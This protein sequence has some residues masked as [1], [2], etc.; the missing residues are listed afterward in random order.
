LG[1]RRTDL[2]ISTK[3][4]WGLGTRKGANDGGLSRKHIIEGTK[5]SLVRLGMDYVDVIFA[6]RHDDHV[7]MEEI[8]RAF[9]FVI[10]QGWA[11]YWGTSEWSAQR[12]E[13]AYHVATKLKLI[14]PIAE[15]CQYNMIKRDKAEKEYLPLYKNYEYG[16]TVF[17]PL[18]FGLLT[19][20]YNDGIPDGSRFAT[21][22]EFKD[23][24]KD[25]F[26][27]GEKTTMDKVR[28]LTKYSKEELGIPPATLALAWL[29]K[30]KNVSTVILGASKPEHVRENLKA[31]EFVPKL[32][33][34][35]V[36]KVEEI[37]GNKPKPDPTYGRPA[38]D[39][40]GR[41]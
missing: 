14:P 39:V 33:D 17:S 7:P 38:L 11:F 32:T 10:E 2:I 5:E 6:H 36:E 20:K 31:L 28:A 8:V 19:G 16:V 35:V 30:N 21:E 1:L 24:V 40:Y 27:G 29:I 18:Q 41:A 15:Q 25:L 37:L 4:F 3:I 23:Y 13:E 22:D 9:N 12:I 34:E 26:E